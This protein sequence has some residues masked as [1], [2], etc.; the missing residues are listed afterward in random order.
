MLSRSHAPQEAAARRSATA[1]CAR[2]AASALLALSSPETGAG[3]GAS[4]PSPHSVF[5]TREPCAPPVAGG[6]A[7]RD[8]VE[9]APGVNRCPRGEGDRLRPGDPVG[10]RERNCSRA[11]RD[12][13]SSAEAAAPAAATALSVALA[14]ARVDGEGATEGGRA[15]AGRRAERGITGAAGGS[16]REEEEEPGLSS[17]LSRDTA[18]ELA[19]GGVTPPCTGGGARKEGTPG[20]AGVTGESGEGEAAYSRRAVCAGRGWAGIHSAHG[21]S[22]R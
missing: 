10:N 15:G 14:A 11:A 1:C 3:A 19:V 20:G 22:A 16:S 17:V 13:A 5:R 2:A 9:A 4:A 18:S 7:N 6:V 8:A 21:S 12:A